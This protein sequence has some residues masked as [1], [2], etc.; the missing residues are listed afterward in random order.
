MSLVTDAIAGIFKP[1][2]D[3][4]DHVVPSGDAKVA[5]QSA[6]LAGKLQA[7]QNTID[8]ESKL[9][10]SKTSIIAAEAKSESFIAANWRPITMLTFLVLV[11]LDSLGYLPNRLAPEAWTLLQMGIG[12]YVVGRSVEKVAPAVTAAISAATGKK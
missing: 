7:A 8:Y 11:V 10:D 2:E 6:T 9:L 3:V 12:G 1:I 4:I 5:L